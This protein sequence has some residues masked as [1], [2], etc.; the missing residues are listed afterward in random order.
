M[1]LR[2]SSNAISLETQI[3]QAEYIVHLAKRQQILYTAAEASKEMH[4]QIL[5]NARLMGGKV[6]YIVCIEEYEDARLFL[7]AYQDTARKLHESHG[8]TPK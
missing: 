2:D 4:W 7:E 1:L 5:R 6:Q 3:R 8:K